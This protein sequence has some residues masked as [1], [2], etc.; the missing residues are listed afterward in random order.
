MTKGN[1]LFFFITLNNRTKHTHKQNT[2]TKSTFYISVEQ[3]FNV[4]AGC[5]TTQSLH[6]DY[7][8]HRRSCRWTIAVVSS[9][10]RQSFVSVRQVQLRR[11]FDDGRP[12]AEGHPRWH[13]QP[14]SNPSYSVAIRR[15]GSIRWG[16]GQG[17]Q[18]PSLWLDPQIFEGFPVFITDIV[19]VMTW[20]GPGV[21][22]PRILGLEPRLAI[23]L[24][25]WTARSHAARNTTY[26]R[27]HSL[28]GATLFSKRFT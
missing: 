5:R 15:R 27:N 12:S 28:D 9:M 19:F 18:A 7:A 17:T 25:Q 24:A 8:I 16:R 4:S 22:P 1:S 13:N 3:E 2:Y 11:N 6:D 14:G 23:C 20:R 21:R 26:Y 10:P